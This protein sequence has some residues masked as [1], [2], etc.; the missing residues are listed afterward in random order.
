MS[1]IAE[2][3][4]TYA[5]IQ[6]RE[7]VVAGSEPAVLLLHGFG[8][9]ADTWRPVLAQLREAGQ[10]A[11]AVDLPG[12]GQAAALDAGELLP[13]LDR[14]VVAAVRAHAGTTGVVVVGNSLGGAAVV[15]AARNRDLPV[16]AVMAL[17]IAGIAWRG[18]TASL[19]ALTAALRILSAMP[20]PGLAHR[21]VLRWSLS[22]L[23]Y[24]DRSAI[25]REVV[26]RFVDNY[27]SAS[28]TYRSV[29]LGAMFKAELDRTGHHGG[30]RSPLVVLH[31]ARDSL[32]PVSASRILHEANPGSR[33]I[34][35]E[36][37]GHCPQLDAPAIVAYHAR[38]LAVSS[39]AEA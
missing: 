32:V 31:G 8:D 19:G 29:R 3:R 14:F 13:Q 23:L 10:A 35:I 26:A 2:R 24:G 39:T 22:R 27:P 18:P 34:V 9:S 17:G 7:L 16:R 21:A 33:L 1:S 6:T 28:A 5:G 30:I 36:T 15:R 12:F 20:I 11:I 38:Q 4:S 25:D 37:A